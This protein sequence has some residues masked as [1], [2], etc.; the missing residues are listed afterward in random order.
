MAEWNGI[1]SHIQR[2]LWEGDNR[3]TPCCLQAGNRKVAYG[4]RNQIDRKCDLAREGTK[5]KVNDQFWILQ[6]EELCSNLGVK[7]QVTWFAVCLCRSRPERQK[8][9]NTLK[10]FLDKLCQQNQQRKNKINLELLSVPRT[11][12]PDEPHKRYEHCKIQN[13]SEKGVHHT[14]PKISDQQRWKTDR[15]E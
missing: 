6:G 8:N 4:A 12:S 9:T 1:A 2:Q 11:F 7:I 14:V 10:P 5:E 15:S 13:A 3:A